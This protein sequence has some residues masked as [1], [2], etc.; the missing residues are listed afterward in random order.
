[1]S[2]QPSLGAKPGHHRICPKT[3]ENEFLVQRFMDFFPLKQ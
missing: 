3:V 2:F 1:M